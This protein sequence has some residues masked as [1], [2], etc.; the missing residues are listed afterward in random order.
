[1]KIIF[2]REAIE[3]LVAIGEYIAESNPQ[4]AASFVTDLEEK[5][6]DLANRP[7]AFA[8]LARPSAREIRRRRSGKYLI[9]YE[10]GEERI[11]ILH[12]LHGARDYDRI[13]FPEDNGSSLELDR[14]PEQK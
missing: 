2:A 13:L 9:F 12:I 11:E 1:M 3:D 5:S 10:V 6:L 14:E 4:R 7:F 8:R